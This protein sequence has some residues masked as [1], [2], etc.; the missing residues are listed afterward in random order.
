MAGS[1]CCVKWPHER[2]IDPAHAWGV[3]AVGTAG[4]VAL[5]TILATLHAADAHF[6]WWWPSGWMAVPAAIFAAGAAL[7]ALSA[8]PGNAPQ[9]ATDAASGAASASSAKTSPPRPTRPDETAPEPQ[10]AGAWPRPAAA[11]TKG[12]VFLSAAGEDAGPADW[13]Q[14]ELEAAG[15]RVW[16]D[17]RDL[18]PGD[19]RPAAIRKAITDGAL[20]FLACFSSRS[21]TA[22][23]SYLNV[24]LLLAVD[25]QRMRR[26]GASWLI[27]VRF[28]DCPIPDIDLG[29]GRALTSLTTADLF[30]QHR[31][32]QAERLVAAIRRILG[33]ST[34]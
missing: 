28:D 21:S 8:R 33:S 2:R 27:P 9:L 19:E 17:A 32:A 10:H 31:D 29:G 11:E 3:V 1:L 6:R 34:G 18:S 4:L 26:P 22:V 12:H 20:V 5:P 23:R 16:R 13:L 14:H 25:E 24:Q 30:G 7:V 15:I